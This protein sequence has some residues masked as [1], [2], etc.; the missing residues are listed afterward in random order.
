MSVPAYKITDAELVIIFAHEH[1]CSWYVG[2]GDVLCGADYGV[3]ASC[4]CLR[5]VRVLREAIENPLG[6]ATA[7]VDE[8]LAEAEK[9]V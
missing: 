6:A 1:G 9:R 4:E 5:I 7:I 2:D 8:K 3:G